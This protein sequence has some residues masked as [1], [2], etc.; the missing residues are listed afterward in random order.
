[1]ATLSACESPQTRDSNLLVDS[2]SRAAESHATGWGSLRPDLPQL[3]RRPEPR[4]CSF[5]FPPSRK[6]HAADSQRDA[7]STAVLA[8]DMSAKLG[9]E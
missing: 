4:R 9:D 3:R 8:A 2:R 5:C 6:V 1:M 7:V